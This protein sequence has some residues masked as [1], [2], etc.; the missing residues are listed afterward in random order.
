[1]SD[2]VLRPAVPADVAQVAAIWTTG[3]RDGHLEHSPAALVAVRTPESFAE[4]AGDR[5]ADTRVAVVLGE[6]GEE[7]AGFTMVGTDEVEQVYVASA[8]RGSGVAGILLAD[9]ARRVREA[10]HPTAWLAVATGNAR[11]RHFYAREGWVDE[12]EFSY[13]AATTSG[14]MNVPCHRFTTSGGA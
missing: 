12:G 8:H 11:A 6:T 3:W 2:V 5:V 4:R 9:A 1:M 7:I 14:V 13:P 10:G